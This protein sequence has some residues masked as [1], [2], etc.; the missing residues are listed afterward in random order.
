MTQQQV[1]R[2]S[3]TLVEAIRDGDFETPA[4]MGWNPWEKWRRDVGLRP[5]ARTDGEATTSAQESA[6]WKSTMLELYGDDWPLKLLEQ[7]EEL[8][9]ATTQPGEPSEQPAA[10]AYDVQPFV[11]GEQPAEG[12]RLETPR[13]APAAQESQGPGSGQGP[14]PG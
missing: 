1:S 13:R 4:L 11:P 2:S 3:K 10:G 8:V 6:L 12:A 7:G 5:T 9:V 14:S